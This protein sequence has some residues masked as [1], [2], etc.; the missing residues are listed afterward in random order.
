M[1]RS[2]VTLN[3]DQQRAVASA[4]RLLE[5]RLV[6]IEGVMERPDSGILYRR[7]RASFG[8]ERQARIEATVAELRATVRAVAEAFDLPRE[9]QDPVRKIIGLLA[10]SWESVG[11]IDVRRLAGYGAVDP[12]LRKTLNPMIERL[13]ELISKLEET[14]GTPGDRPAKSSSE[15]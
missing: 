7:D 15:D 14:V 6:I 12:G 1:A 8:R 11:Q 3:P 4:L 2:S 9:E 10:I 13:M 5:E